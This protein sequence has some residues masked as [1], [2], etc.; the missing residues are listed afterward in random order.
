MKGASGVTRPLCHLAFA[1]C[2]GAF[3]VAPEPLAAQTFTSSVA[4]GVAGLSDSGSSDAFR[5]QYNLGE[6]FF[7]EDLA[8]TARGA[9][10]RETL[11][12]SAWGFGGAEPAQ[13]A[14]L[15]WFPNDCWKVALDY[16][17]RESFLGLSEADVG[18]RQDDWDITRWRGKLTWDGA[19]WGKVSLKL[20]HHDRSGTVRMPYF[21]LNE[22]YPLR[23]E[24]DEAFTEAALR[25][26]STTDGPFHFSVEPSYGL[27]ERENRW[28]PDGAGTDPDVL[29][30]ASSTRKDEQTIPGV[31]ATASW[32]SGHFEALGNVLWSGSDLDATGE[33][34]VAWDLGGGSIGRVEHVDRT[35]GSASL[36][37]LAGNLRLG[38]GLG[39]GFV[40][41][42]A[43]EA[44]DR[45]T[46]STLLGQRLLRLSN[47][48]GGGLEIPGAVSEA[49]L[50]D[51]RDVLGRA[52]LALEKARFGI[53]AGAF[54]ATRE[55][56]YKA[57]AADALTD[58]TRDTEGF[59]AGFNVSLPARFRLNVDYEHGS[60]TDYVFRTD[61]ETVDRLRGRL[62]GELGGGFSASLHGRWEKAENPSAV[63]G[64]DRK[65][66][67]GGLSLAWDAP[68]GPHGLS[69]DVETVDLTSDTGIL[70]P[71]ATGAPTAGRSVY[72]L[73]LL[74][75]SAGAR[76]G[77]G[78]VTLSADGSW[79]E[80][81]GETWPL[82]A[83]TA[84]GRLS[85][86][87]PASLEASAFVQY[88]K[89]DEEYADRDDYRVTRY[90]LVLRWE[91]A[92]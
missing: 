19:S 87:L 66:A 81:R 16:D 75:F 14:R 56:S 13:A 17:R 29:A 52:E 69:V 53:R 54:L 61:P 79:I 20:R 70:F 25:F 23:V 57:T 4:A 62:R 21:G 46:D 43:G 50:F 9:D 59:A 92:K 42:L 28:Y 18:T 10:G 2:L 31:R 36:D 58:V 90:G 5:S 3:F 82:R 32:R 38:F 47:P 76:T 60:F 64:L 65:N 73:S 12:V 41:R 67:S 1:T 80:D 8:L 39:G 71:G 91:L 49:G 34:S 11:N 85:V 40:L 89:Y 86:K 55:V 78:P 63:A 15:S 35:I 37:T 72:D 88:W 33:R 26:E 7:L 27:F 84:R 48:A 74:T 51:T 30:S 77:L 6:G 45:T 68:K 22:L 83:T 24:L 44:R